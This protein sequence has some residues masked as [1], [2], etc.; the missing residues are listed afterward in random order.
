MQVLDSFV[1]TIFTLPSGYIHR[2]LY[3]FCDFFV[4]IAYIETLKVFMCQFYAFYDT[5]A[6][7]I[8]RLFHEWKSSRAGYFVANALVYFLD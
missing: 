6:Y 4:H 1:S 3:R 8:N 7:S 5:I 2:S